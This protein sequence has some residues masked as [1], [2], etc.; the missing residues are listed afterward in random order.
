[1]FEKVL[2]LIIF[3]LL[4]FSRG[5]IDV[6]TEISHKI[7]SMNVQR[8]LSALD[9]HLREVI[10]HLLLVHEDYEMREFLET[11]KAHEI[12]VNEFMV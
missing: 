8:H 12:T 3:F 11:F 10:E 9:S 1:M 5:H 7:D 6:L 2:L 4:I